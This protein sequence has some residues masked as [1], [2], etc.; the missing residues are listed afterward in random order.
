MRGARLAEAL[1]EELGVPVYDSIATTVWK[2]LQLAGVDPARVRGWGS[3]FSGQAAPRIT[4]DEPATRE[5]Q[6]GSRR[7]S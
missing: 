6:A 4:A 2:S 3:L 5:V 1:E 7:R